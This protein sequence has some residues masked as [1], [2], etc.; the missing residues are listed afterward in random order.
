MNQEPLWC[1]HKNVKKNI[2]DILTNLHKKY[3][4]II[5]KKS[6]SVTDIRK[7]LIEL[8]HITTNI[9]EYIHTY[10]EKLKDY[11]YDQKGSNKYGY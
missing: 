9:D 11:I 7:Q 6:S 10:E 3:E 8:Q 2:G 4:F 5:K 1:I